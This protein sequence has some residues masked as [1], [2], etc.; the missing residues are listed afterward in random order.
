[1]KKKKK[2]KIEESRN[3]ELKKI[4]MRMQLMANFFLTRIE[5]TNCS[6]NSSL[7]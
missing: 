1:M 7:R 3:R 6:R 5:C 4:D 2:K